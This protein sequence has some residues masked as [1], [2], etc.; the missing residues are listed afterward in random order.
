MTS[1]LKNQK[2]ERTVRWSLQFLIRMPEGWNV[3][4][5]FVDVRRK[6]AHSH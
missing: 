2:S 6:A 5:D 3:L 1:F 4:K